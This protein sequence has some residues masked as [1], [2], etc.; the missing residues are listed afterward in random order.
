MKKDSL[1]WTFIATAT[2]ACVRVMMSTF[3]SPV[4]TAATRL[5][6]AKRCE[7]DR[8]AHL[9]LA[10]AHRPKRSAHH[11]GLLRIGKH[12][13]FTTFASL[14]TRHSSACGYRPAS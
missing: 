12:F 13:V 10:A 9:A 7:D 4:S 6:I 11:L 8:F 1:F 5:D 3:A 2:V 14:R